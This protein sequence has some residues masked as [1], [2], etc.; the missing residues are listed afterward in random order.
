MV[1]FNFVVMSL[2]RNIL[3]ESLQIL[4]VG[5]GWLLKKFKDPIRRVGDRSSENGRVLVE[6]YVTRAIV[7][8]KVILVACTAI[9]V[10]QYSSLRFLFNLSRIRAKP[11]SVPSI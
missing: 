10:Y 7:T 9:W 5:L 6:E 4:K 3:E 2:C 8:S 11:V 1:N